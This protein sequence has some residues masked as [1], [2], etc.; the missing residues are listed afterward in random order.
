MDNIS[1]LGSLFKKVQYRTSNIPRDAANEFL[2]YEDKPD[3]HVRIGR[4]KRKD[5]YFFLTQRYAAKFKDED[6]FYDFTV[7]D[8]WNEKEM[9]VFSCILF[10][11]ISG[12]SK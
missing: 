9:Y 1:Q 8:L 3:R 7:F 11:Y 2:V 4:F 5:V 6:D 10:K 12:T